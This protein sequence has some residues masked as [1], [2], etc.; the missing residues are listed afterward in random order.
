M[1]NLLNNAIPYVKGLIENERILIINKF[2]VNE[3]GFPFEK[4]EKIETISHVQPLN[5]YQVSKITGSTLDSPIMMRFYIIG[6][7]ANVL[8]SIQKTDC[9]IQWNERS[10]K[11]FSK[12]DWSLNG[13]ISVIGT[14]F[15][16][17]DEE[18]SEYFTKGDENV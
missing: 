6:N 7:L 11:I 15:L 2:I 17:D 4:E 10:F 5:P 9:V 13:W 18:A 8:N 14:E 1:L 3:E 12:Q 16:G